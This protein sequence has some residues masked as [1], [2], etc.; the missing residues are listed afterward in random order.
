[1]TG[2]PALPASRVENPRLCPFE[3]RIQFRLSSVSALDFCSLADVTWTGAKPNQLL[4]DGVRPFTTLLFR[5][6]DCGSYF[7]EAHLVKRRV[8]LEVSRTLPVHRACTLVACRNAGGLEV[9][10]C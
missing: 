10:P 8:V 6:H 3:R 2:A 9:A 4:D 5:F 7:D 1:M